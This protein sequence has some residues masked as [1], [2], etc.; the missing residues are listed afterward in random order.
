MKEIFW[1]V[2]PVVILFALF[3]V[4][5]I[6]PLAF[7]DSVMCKSKSAQM[8]MNHSWGMLQ[9]CLIEYEPRKWIPIQNYRVVEK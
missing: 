4:V 8:G 6:A 1:G 3:L 9:G 2:A 7:L 5:V